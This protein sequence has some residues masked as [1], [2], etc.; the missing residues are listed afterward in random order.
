MDASVGR[1]ARLFFGEARV[2]AV[3]F[4]VVLGACGGGRERET[5]DGGSRD[6]AMR[7]G[8][9]SDAG[10]TGATLEAHINLSDLGDG[11]LFE[12]LVRDLYAVSRHEVIVVGSET[13][14]GGNQNVWV[15]SIDA[16]S[17]SFRWSDTYNG[18]ENAADY[19]DASHRF[20]DG[21]LVALV[22]SDRSRWLASYDASGTR[23]PFV[24]IPYGSAVRMTARASGLVLGWRILSDHLIT[25]VG[26]DE[27][28]AEVWQTTVDTGDERW[29]EV[30]VPGRDG[31]VIAA[32][33]IAPDGS[34]EEKHALVVKLSDAGGVLW[35]R[36]HD[37]N[38]DGLSATITHDAAARADGSVV[39]AGEV[40]DPADRASGRG[41]IASYDVDGTLG[42][43]SLVGADGNECPEVSAVAIDPR[44]GDAVVLC[45]GRFGPI[46]VFRLSPE[47]AES[48]PTVVDRADAIEL[49]IAPDG[50]I[51]VV[52]S[53]VGVLHLISLVP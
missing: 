44:N 11:H 12:R 5:G 40:A 30:L 8:G 39:I 13:P 4:A 28:S 15:A 6:L 35:Q 31:G 20:E 32:G 45:D 43:S 46:H 29:L 33:E 37:P 10:S 7:D 18:T 14:W 50:T 26:I 22:F 3:A 36:T 9:T 1:P 48:G 21:R 53:S 17:E 2:A 47:G 52:G 49:A 25:L 38:P 27:S 51:W 34:S 23:A 42:W 16:E 41:W 19:V 24:E